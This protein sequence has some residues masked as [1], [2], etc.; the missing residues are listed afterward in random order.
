MYDLNDYVDIETMCDLL[1]CCR[2]TA[3]R[4]LKAEDCHLKHFRI[5]RNYKIRLKDLYEFMDEQANTG[6]RLVL[7]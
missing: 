6:S 4:I 1:S 2:T 7:A 5:G 3:Y